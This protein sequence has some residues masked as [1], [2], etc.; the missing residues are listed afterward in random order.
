MS[1]QPPHPTSPEEAVVLAERR[2]SVLLL[3]LN[4]PQRLNAWTQE[5]EDLYL[6][7]LAEA[8]ADREG[9]ASF[10]E[11]RAPDFPPLAG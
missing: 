9:V 3:T 4:R 2:S 10:S 1:E 6:S 7:H 8:D 5:V 11:R